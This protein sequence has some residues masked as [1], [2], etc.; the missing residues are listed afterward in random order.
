MKVKFRMYVFYACTSVWR[1]IGEWR[2][3]EERTP[4]CMNIYSPT[5]FLVRVSHV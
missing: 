5:F 3:R 2:L 4:E 1:R